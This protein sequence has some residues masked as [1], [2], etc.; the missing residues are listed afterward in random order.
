MTEHDE[1]EIV[2]IPEVGRIYEN[3]FPGSKRHKYLC[4][5][6]D[7]KSFCPYRMKGLTTNSSSWYSEVCWKEVKDDK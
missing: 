6:F 4:I 7:G 1:D 3:V 5:D 2:D